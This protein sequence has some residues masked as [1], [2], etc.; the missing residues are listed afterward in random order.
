MI[1]SSELRVVFRVAAGPRRGFGHLVRCLSLARAMGVRPLLSVKGGDGVAHTALTL[2]GDV[3]SD[4]SSRVLARM[5]P[6]VVVID[7][8]IARTARLWVAAAR[9]VGALVVT[10]HDLGIGCGDADVVIDGSLTR[11]ARVSKDRIG[12]IGSQYAIVDPR[13]PRH[14]RRRRQGA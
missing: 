7:D 3:L 10:I 12:L 5:R 9:G 1:R 4:S 8:P 2:G 6:D 11:Q 14:A 13:L